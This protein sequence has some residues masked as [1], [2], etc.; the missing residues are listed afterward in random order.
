MRTLFVFVFVFVFVL[1]FCHNRIIYN[2]LEFSTIIVQIKSIN[3][4]DFVKDITVLPVA[5]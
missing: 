4:P 2:F 1:A 3:K 5:N